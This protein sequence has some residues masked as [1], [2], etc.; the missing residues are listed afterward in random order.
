MNNVHDMGGMQGYGPVVEEVNE[1][2]F[3]HAWESRALAVTLAM[4]ATGKWNIDQARSAR[5]SLPALTYL[6]I[7]YYQIWFEA[8]EKLLVQV[9][10]VTEEELTAGKVLESPVEGVRKLL[11]D[12]VTATLN[13][14]GPTEREVQTVALFSVGQSVRTRQ[15]N[16][17]THTRLPRYCRDKPGVIAAVHGGHVYPDTNGCGQGEQPKWLYTVRFDAKDL[18]GPDT[19]ASAVHVDCWE[20]Y[21]MAVQA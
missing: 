6:S 18:W 10:L 17:L 4:G 14:G 15:M 20:P 7:A 13:R 1:P 21:L 5:E 9:G 16:P 8:L 2:L 12:N 3:H 11:K 19:T